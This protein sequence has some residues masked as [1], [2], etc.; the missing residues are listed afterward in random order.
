M[1][2]LESLK[3]FQLKNEM[4]EIN[5]GSAFWGF[6]ATSQLQQYA[7]GSNSILGSTGYH[8]HKNYLWIT[9]DEGDLYTDTYNEATGATW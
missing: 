6:H 2:K 5:G 9:V 1:K 3:E 4:N 7:S 8:G